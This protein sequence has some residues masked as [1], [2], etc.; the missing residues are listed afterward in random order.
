MVQLSM[1]N[2]VVLYRTDFQELYV[3][4]S[5]IWGNLI[6]STPEIQPIEIL[7]SLQ[8]SQKNRSVSRR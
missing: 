5:Y 8:M 2:T 6:E 3:H 1:E 7:H 4:V